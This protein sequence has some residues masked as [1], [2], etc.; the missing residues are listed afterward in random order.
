MDPTRLKHLEFLQATISRMAQHSFAIRTLAV[1][2]V[3]A[4]ATYALN[5]KTP[6]ILVGAIAAAV[7]FWLLDAFYLHLERAFRALYDEVRKGAEASDFS[8]KTA[9]ENRGVVPYLGAVFSRVNLLFY[10]TLVGLTLGAML[11]TP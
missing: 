10:L 3:A 11:C 8:M 1:T 6:D 7:V 4:A 5:A 2:V 9:A